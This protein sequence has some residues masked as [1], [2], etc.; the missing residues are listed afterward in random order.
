MGEMGDDFRAW[1]DHKRE[2][3]AKHTEECPGCPINRSPTKLFEGQTCRV[4]GYRRPHRN[5]RK[6]KPTWDV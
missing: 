3:R 6:A 2:M 5:D 4:C 1:R